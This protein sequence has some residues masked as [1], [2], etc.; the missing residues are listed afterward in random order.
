MINP[1]ALRAGKSI[2]LKGNLRILAL[3][4]SLT[5]AGLFL[6]WDLHL[7]IPGLIVE[8]TGVAI[9]IFSMIR[10]IRYLAQERAETARL[11]KEW[12]GEIDDLEAYIPAHY[13]TV[14]REL[15]PSS[16]RLPDVAALL[17]GAL[18]RGHALE[19]GRELW[20]PPDW[21]KTTNLAQGKICFGV[22]LL[23]GDDQSVSVVWRTDDDPDAFV[24]RFP[25]GAP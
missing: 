9:N 11:T 6:N 8:Y 20:I 1:L 16:Q 22:T 5:L 10:S 19:E 3:G 7:V 25:V 2:G 17:A 12:R 24:A 21:F 13:G 4:V 18:D 15:A 14:L 23:A